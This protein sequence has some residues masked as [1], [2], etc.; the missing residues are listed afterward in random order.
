MNSN[1]SYWLPHHQHPLEGY[2]RI[3]GCER[4]DRS[5]RQRLGYRIVID[6]LSSLFGDAY[7]R[8]DGMPGD[9]VDVPK[10]QAMLYGNATYPDL[11]NRNLLAELV[12]DDLVALCR[13][14]APIGVASDD[15]AL[16]DLTLACDVLENWD[17][18]H[19]LDSVGAHLFQEWWRLVPIAASPV[20][21][22][23][24]LT[25]FDAN[26]PVNTPRDLNVAN[27][28]VRQA[29]VDAV[30]R[31]SELGLPLDA[32]LGEVQYV[33]RNGVA[34]PIHGG[35]GTLGVFNAINNSL[36]S[37]PGRGYDVPHGSSYIQTVTW[38][39]HGPQAGMILTY[40][41]STDPA[42]PHYSDLT[43]LYSQ[44]GWLDV[45]FSDAEIRSD[46]ELERIRLSE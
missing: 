46:P 3:I 9:D 5:L 30:D 14:P 44:Q 4:C 8:P 37:T 25:P 23:A 1:D 26:D 34:I 21:D 18:R 40:S 39:E 38:D 17:L 11:G 27:P 2:A 13:T 19:N 28:K 10:L 29:L 35:P 32:P 20:P 22:L 43:E 16:I 24:W 6:R 45:P 15:A 12:R 33:E 31:L 42:S 36:S 7:S 41:Q